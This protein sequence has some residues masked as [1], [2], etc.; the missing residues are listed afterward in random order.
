[1]SSSKE[2]SKWNN[3]HILNIDVS[4][5]GLK[6]FTL[7]NSLHVYGSDTQEIGDPFKLGGVNLFFSNRFVFDAPE[8]SVVCKGTVCVKWGIPSH[9]YLRWLDAGKLKF[10]NSRC[11]RRWKEK[12]KFI[13]KIQCTVSLYRTK[14]YEENTFSTPLIKIQSFLVLGMILINYFL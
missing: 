1:M 6:F 3:Y 10:D 2:S 7:L 8:E 12:K 14:L 9:G 4:I 11:S 13:V 5:D